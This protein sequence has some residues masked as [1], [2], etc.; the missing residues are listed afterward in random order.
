MKLLSSIL[1]TALSLTA[2]QLPAQDAEA[3]VT[4]GPMTGIKGKPAPPLGVSTWI[5]LPEG[6]ERLGIPD[7]KDKVLVVFCFQS[8]CLACEKREF[9]VL[10]QLVEE[11]EGNEDIGFLA[12]Q[13]PFEDF[14]TNSELQLKPTAE[15]HE[16]S[17]PFGHLAKTPETWSINLAYQT[18]GTPWW[19]VI[20]REGTVVF[21]DFTMAPDVAAANLRTLIAG[22]SVE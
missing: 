9:P 22:D 10:K 4:T 20:D 1:I 11:F 16:L 15:K 18:G 3:E 7:F 14:A 19:I 6:K 2:I 21:N 5:Q 8:T 17:I 12:I 13:T